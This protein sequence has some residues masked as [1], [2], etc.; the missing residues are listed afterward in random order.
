MK[1]AGAVCQHQG[2]AVFVAADAFDGLAILGGYCDGSDSWAATFLLDVIG[3][4]QLFEECFCGFGRGIGEIWAQDSATA[5]DF[6]ATGASGFAKEE[7]LA[8]LRIARDDFVDLAACSIQAAEV[9][10]D[11]P[12]LRNLELAESRHF[13]ACDAIADVEEEFAVLCAV[14]EGTGR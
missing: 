2:E 1:F 13:S 10:D 5:A 7:D 12:D 11:L 3:V 9:A 8:I 4:L 14:L 6:V